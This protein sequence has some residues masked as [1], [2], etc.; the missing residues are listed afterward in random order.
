MITISS[1]AASSLLRGNQKRFVRVE[2]W[3]DDQLLSDNLPVEGGKEDVDR[4]S[5]VP[6]RVTFSVPIRSGGVDYTP[7]DLLSPLAANGQVIRVSLGIEI[8]FE[9]IEWMQRG[10]FV[11]TDSEVRDDAVE[12][13]A[14]GLLWKIDEAR[15]V[16]PYQPSGTFKSAI[17]KLVEP[18]LTVE[19]DSTLVDRAVPAGINYDDDRLAALQTTL[20]AWPA[21]AD[22]TEEGYLLVSPVADPVTVSVA[23]STGPGGTVISKV[24]R[25]TRDGVY[26][27]VVVEGQTADGGVVRGVAYDLNGPK[28]SGGPFNELPMPLFMSSPLVTTAAQAQAAANSRLLTLKRSLSFTYDVEMVPHPALQAGDLVTLDGEPGVIERL[29]TP[30]SAG[31]GSQTATIRMVGS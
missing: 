6:E 25:S 7:S 4:G 3:Y 22:V 30:W 11:I 16:S 12:V 1:A 24:G 9:E 2:S 29:S 19:F 15:L 5:N 14:A 18:A 13:E 23:L 8:A 21:R 20:D 28:R 26:N 10:W 27:A 17:Q 31:G